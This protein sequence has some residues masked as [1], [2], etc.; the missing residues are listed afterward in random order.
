MKKP[1]LLVIGIIIGIL[2]GALV[3]ELFEMLAPTGMVREFFTKGVNF[4]M[5]TTTID[6]GAITFT[7]G[8]TLNFTVISF[9][10]LIVM[11]YYLLL[12]PV[13]ATN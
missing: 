13:I 10:V 4:G 7:F 5:K 1:W 9:V 2:A 3:S 12:T 11:I 6:L 8:F